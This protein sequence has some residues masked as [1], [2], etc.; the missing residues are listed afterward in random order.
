MPDDQNPQQ[1]PP[2][3]PADNPQMPPPEDNSFPAPGELPPLTDTPAVENQPALN[4]AASGGDNPPLDIPPVVSPPP[5]KKFGPKAIVAGVLGLLLL[6]GGIGAGILLVQQ[7]QDIREK[8][9]TNSCTG[10]F[11]PCP[12][13]GVCSNIYPSDVCTNLGATQCQNATTV[14]KC[15][16]PLTQFCSLNYW[17]YDQ[18][19]GAGQSCLDGACVSAGDTAS[20]SP[21]PSGGGGGGSD[22]RY[23]RDEAAGAVGLAGNC[24]GY[25]FRALVFECNGPSSLGNNGRC[26]D[27]GIHPGYQST[28]VD[29]PGATSVNIGSVGNCKSRQADLIVTGRPEGD[30]LDGDN[31]PGTPVVAN[32]I[33]KDGNQSGCNTPPPPASAPASAPASSAGTTAFCQ[34]IKAYDTNWAQLGP[35]QLAALQVG[36]HVRFAVRGSAT[37]GTFTKAIFKVN[38]VDSNEITNKK[39]GTEEYFYEY[40]IPTG[41]T[42]ITVEGF[43]F[44]S[45]LGWNP[46]R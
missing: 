3:A 1:N 17:K 36:D 18:T 14:V 33:I 16:G 21:S 26:E 11:A 45:T 9:S 29:Q 42:A 22:C 13:A 40:T 35:S 27:K 15:S 30:P 12:E 2:P 32:F 19:C 8:A 6:V 31:L 5:K 23:T 46:S 24:S 4:M 7:Q 41:A 28:P 25:T 44:H 20:P 37:G 10:G 43:V 34:Q 39:P 38:G